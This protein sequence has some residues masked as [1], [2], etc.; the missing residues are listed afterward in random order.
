MAG[1]KPLLRGVPSAV[2]FTVFLAFASVYIPIL[3][4]FTT[5]IWAVPTAVLTARTGLGQGM[6]AAI[7][8]FAWLAFTVSPAWAS[9]AA[10]QFAGIGLVLGFLLRKSNSSSRVI[11]ITV[12]VSLL[13]TGA[14]FSFPLLLG[15]TPGSF[16]GRT[17]EQYLAAFMT[18]GNPWGSLPLC[19]SR[20]YPRKRSKNHCSR[21]WTGSLGCCLPSW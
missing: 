18:Y 11:I 1:R 15:N 3:G 20:E 21:Q 16:A 8:S 19:R 12:V 10:L 17:A 6:L 4:L 9:M 2:I 13:I 7:L 14:V 5:F